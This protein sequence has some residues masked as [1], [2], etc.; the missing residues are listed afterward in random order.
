MF[1]AGVVG[2]VV[3]GRIAHGNYS[4]DYSCHSQHSNYREYGD[5]GMVD[6]IRDK[7]RSISQIE[8]NIK[9]VRRRM[10]DDF[11]TQME[12]LK[13]EASYDALSASPEHVMEKIKGDMKREIEDSIEKEQEEL[14]EIDK[15][16]D[17]INTLALNETGQ[18]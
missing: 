1:V 3:V 10:E 5:S 16:I 7:E 11:R 4:D 9:D 18:E 2:V 17:K 6:E 15:I 13:C 12:S 8:S 14:A